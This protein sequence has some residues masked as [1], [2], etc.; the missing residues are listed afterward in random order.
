MTI[1]KKI[2][3]LRKEKHLSQ[4]EL[5]D[6]IGVS[7]Q[8]ISKWELDET[9]PD[10]KQVSKITDYFQISME[11]FLSD[12][13][14]NFTI[15][16]EKKNLKLLKISITILLS[17]LVVEIVFA[18]A[19]FVGYNK[20]DSGRTIFS[21]YNMICHL[22]NQEYAIYVDYDNSNNI[23]YMDGDSYIFDNIVNKKKYENANELNY[24]I[25]TYFQKNNG[26]CR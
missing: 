13:L 19:Y 2:N 6:K 7:R 11:N 15:N 24:D 17:I 14:V 18:I 21:R 23:I 26:I 12:D 22:N 8:T 10:I 25:Q 20:A 9:T 4:E 1:G 5:A 3:E 16:A